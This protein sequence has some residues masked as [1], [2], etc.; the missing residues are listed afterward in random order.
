M[1]DFTLKT[2]LSILLILLGGLHSYA[3][4]A[5]SRYENETSD[6]LLK[7]HFYQGD[8]IKSYSDSQS[9]ENVRLWRT[10]T[11]TAIPDSMV[12]KGLYEISLD[13]LTMALN[14]GKTSNIFLKWI[15]DNK[16]N[17]L[18]EFLLL[19]KELEEL[20][21]NRVSAWYYPSDKSGF[22]EVSDEKGKFQ[23]IISTCRS[24]KTGRLADRYA[25]QAIRAYMSLGEYQN[26]IDYYKQTL[27]RYP[28]RNLFKRMA[29]GYIAGCYAR[30]GDHV[31]ADEM[32]A[33]LGDFA[34][35]SR[36]DK[37][38]FM[39]KV[40][41]ESDIFKTELNYHIGYRD[42]TDNMRFYRIADIALKSPKT[43]HRGDWLYLKAYIEKV[44]RNDTKAALRYV[45]QALSSSF[46]MP[47]MREDARFFN[48]CLTPFH[49]NSQSDIKWMLDNYTTGIWERHI[50]DLLQ[51]KE[52]TKALL[53]A[54]YD[55]EPDTLRYND[56]GMD[57]HTWANTG[58]QML[59][60]C[61]ADEVV[62]YKN[63][64]NHPTM[65]LTSILKPHIRHDSDYL[66][67]IIGTLYLREGKYKSA[68][69]YLSN[70]SFGYQASMNIFKGEYLKYNP[71]DYCYS[72]KDAWYH[73]VYN[74]VYDKSDNEYEY[75]E[76]SVA[77]SK[78]TYLESQTNAKLNFAKE[79]VRLENTIRKERDI[80]K[81]SLA[82]LKYA[83]GRYNSLNTCWALTQYW[84]G[85]SN[86]CFYTGSCK[87][88]DD[89]GKEKEFFIRTPN[90]LKGLDNWFENEVNDIFKTLQNPETIA[91][92]H[93]ILRNYRTLA[94]YFPDTKAGR[95]IASRCDSWNDWL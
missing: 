34:S 49:Q 33:Q 50:S 42:S 60:S 59:L 14:T 36:E 9:E 62:R 1:N 91:E 11:S 23:N 92:I 4:G 71:W 67:E 40:N 73:P 8:R 46:S 89:E 19:A 81:R 48:I 51:K 94:K 28:D 78:V 31:K 37:L 83:I 80:D 26:C 47:Q 54:N 88:V 43:V 69:R 79:M 66:N 17:D 2:Y 93:L 12:I 87:Y 86:Q 38:E 64:L 77:K 74:Y 35:L 76:P 65:T 16:S 29:K 10:L 68:V 6:P 15:Y 3:C 63:E 39:A 44:Y 57:W 61:K 45:R 84:L 22:D 70:V 55:T 7:Y 13:S 27:A 5:F 72:K 90:E 32:F 58:F 52:L 56:I 30:L 25:L 82:R 21:H 20:R 95:I 24:V 53:L 18:K 41:P 85:A 75:Y